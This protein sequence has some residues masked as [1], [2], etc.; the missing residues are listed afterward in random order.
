M[1]LAHYFLF[2][3]QGDDLHLEE[4]EDF[5]VFAEDHSS[6]PEDAY[7]DQVVAA[8]Q[9]IVSAEEFDQVQD[10]FMRNH[11]IVFEDSEVN[12]HEY[13]AIFK[14]YQDTLE[15]YVLTVRYK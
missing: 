3:M 15:K 6:S 7:F 4:G 11:C 10:K 14:L 13:T 1:N 12:K 9:D 2:Q 5:E 8:L